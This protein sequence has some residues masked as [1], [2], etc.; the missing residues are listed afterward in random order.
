MF[1]VIH[2]FQVKS[3]KSR[4]GVAVMGRDEVPNSETQPCASAESTC[5]GGN[6]LV[7]GIS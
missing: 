6:V 1:L 7:N 5:A 4:A 3:K 2:P